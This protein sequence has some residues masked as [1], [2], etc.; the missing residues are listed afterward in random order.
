MR[1]FSTVEQSR[2]NPLLGGVLRAPHTMQAS[3]QVDQV[4][5]QFHLLRPGDWQPE[6]LNV[7]QYCALVLHAERRDDPRAAGR[8]REDRSI[9]ADCKKI[10]VACATPRQKLYRVR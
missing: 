9:L 6:R 8:A 2:Q 4:L 5:G 7:S 3:I 1:W 10:S